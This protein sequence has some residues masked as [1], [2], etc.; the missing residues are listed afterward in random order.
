MI[1]PIKIFTNACQ[2]KMD[3]TNNY[4]NVC[5]IYLWFNRINK[6]TNI[7]NGYNLSRRL[8][9]YYF[10]SKLTCINKFN[11]LSPIN[12][13]ILKYGHKNFSL[14]I[15]EICGDTKLIEKF[16]YLKRE[17][18]YIDLIKPEYNIL[19]KTDSSV[20][21]KH[22]KETKD[23]IRKSL[24]GY[25]HTEDTKLRM[26]QA[27]KNFKYSLEIKEKMSKNRGT[28]IYVFNSKSLNLLMN[29]NSSNKAALYFNCSDTTI[30]KYA[31]NNKIYKEKWIF[32]LKKVL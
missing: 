3:I 32:S 29:F 27:R 19:N 9:E 1:S 12:A 2:Y 17:Q 30:M 7:D 22:L 26:S 25:K 24:L 18:Y 11:Q 16:F 15:L 13:A 5:G 23:K 20:G 28:P 21:F 6:K 14:V 4:K 31:K 10:L 8:A